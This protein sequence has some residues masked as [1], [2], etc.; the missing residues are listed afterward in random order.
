MPTNLANKTVVITGASSGIGRATAQHFAKEGANLVLAARRE[1]AL[2]N[3]A[4]ECQKQGVKTLVVPTDVSDKDA[5]ENLA[6]QAYEEFGSIDVWVNNA[7]VYNMA[8]FEDTPIEEFQRLMDV[9]LMGYV[10]GTRSVLPY[11]RRQGHGN[12][13]MTASLASKVTYPYVS[14]Y[15]ASKH[16]VYAFATAL[17]QE[18]ELDPEAKDIHISLVM[19]ASIDT[20]LFKHTGNHTG[21]VV[22]AMPPVYPPDQVA[23]TIVNMAK[24]PRR[25][26]FVGSA[27][28]VFRLSNLTMPAIAERLFARVADKQH[29]EP[30]QT[31]SPTSGNLFNPVME[32]SGVYGGYGSKASSKRR[33]LF[34]GLAGLI[35]VFLAWRRLQNNRHKK[36]SLFG[37]R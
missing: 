17:R 27:A 19:P 28:R 18:L 3:L 21:R 25:E 20:P 8:R 24:V 36:I 4:E 7:G 13:I 23:R 14:S 22:K 29:F 1:E 12:L 6:R 10:Y 11:F 15:A 16:A 32:G 2:Q 26:A 31:A 37:L 30:G 9:N 33:M 34:A 5:V 35:P